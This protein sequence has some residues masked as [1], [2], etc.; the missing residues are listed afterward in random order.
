[1]KY[2]SNL[3]KKIRIYKIR[4]TLKKT[5]LDSMENNFLNTKKIFDR[6]YFS[7]INRYYSNS[8]IRKIKNLILKKYFLKK[9]GEIFIGNGSDEIIS[10]LNLL[11]SKNVGSFFP[12]FDYS[13]NIRILKKKF[14]KIKLNKSFDISYIKT[15]FLI[16]KKNICMFYIC[17]PNNPTGNFFSRTKI[18][19]LIKENKNCLFILDEA[20]FDFSRKTFVNLIKKYNNLAIIRTFSKIGF[21]GLRIGILIS[22]NKKLIHSLEKI[23]NP[24]NLNFISI[25]FIPQI[26]KLRKKKELNIDHILIEKKRIFK[27]LKKKRRIFFLSK[28]NF[29]LIKISIHERIKI[30]NKNILFKDFNKFLI[31]VSIGN[32][33]ENNKFLK[34]I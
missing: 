22:N 11:S 5:L 21:A 30:K 19:K 10:L 25:N 32:K 17:Y 12:S 26:I 3:V 20:Y 6:N 13:R 31:R 2:I 4:K 1:M 18:I 28:T 7:F 34:I 29:F 8:E 14:F 23:K 33:K 16:K 15:N 9:K 24:F 27:I